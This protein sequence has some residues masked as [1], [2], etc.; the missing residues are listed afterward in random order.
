[1]TMHRMAPLLAMLAILAG[2]IAPVAGQKPEVVTGTI[3]VAP[4]V[5]LAYR[6]MGRG[7]AVLVPGGFLIGTALDALARDRTLILYDMRNRGASSAVRDTAHLGIR[8]DVADL[9]AV[10]AHFG[11]RRVDVIGVSYLGLMVALYA[12]DHPD[13]VG[14]LVQIAPVPRAWDTRYPEALRHDDQPVDS[15]GWDELQ[16]MRRDGT[17]TQQ[18]LCT[19]EW[20]VLRV[21]LV[22][23]RAAAA[24]LPD[25]CGFSN[26][27]PE[28]LSA[29]FAASFGSVRAVRLDARALAAFRRPVL[30]I[31]GTADRNA[32]Y[33]SGRQW[34]MEWPDARLVT[35]AGAAHA[36]WADH[37]PEV[38]D[39]LRTFLA[40]RWPARA[41][42]IT[43]LLP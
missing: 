21:R 19:K 28:H 29:H 42:R 23:E 3:R 36:P 8:D 20:E 32:P 26:E 41:E 4:G 1:M 37:G 14:R 35:V 33:G 30:V 9:E 6:R 17:A 12:L 11:F 34:A 43:R 27:W 31:H 16:R 15:A 39:A 25:P 22:G 40:G 13:R 24:T 7:P 5:D 18:A 2:G 10:R 38:L